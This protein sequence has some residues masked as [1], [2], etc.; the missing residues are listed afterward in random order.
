M[1]ITN[2]YVSNEYLLLHGILEA[3]LEMLATE[4]DVDGC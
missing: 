2:Q 3:I 1:F 4:N